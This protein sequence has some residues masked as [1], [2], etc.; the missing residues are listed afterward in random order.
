M[1]ALYNLFQIL[2]LIAA[3]ALVVYIMNPWSLK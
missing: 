1:W 3:I 2:G